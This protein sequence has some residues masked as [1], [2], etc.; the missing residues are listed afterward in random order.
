M[1]EMKDNQ[2]V[3]VRGEGQSRKWAESAWNTGEIRIKCRWEELTATRA[4]LI[5]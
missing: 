1:N 5:L 4:M 3:V 2:E